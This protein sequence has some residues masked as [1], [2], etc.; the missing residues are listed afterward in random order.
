[1][2]CI[3]KRKNK[4]MK[5]ATI[6]EN[7]EKYIKRMLVATPTTGNIRMEWAMARY[8]QITPVNWSA[9][10]MT[11]WLHPYVP[12]NYGVADA[13]NLITKVAVEENYEWLLL[14]EHDN[15]IPIDAFIKFNQY[16]RENKV[17]VVS[18]L[19]YTRSRP[20]EPLVFRGRGNS[21]YTKWKMGDK[22]WCDAV[23]TGCLLI[24]VSILKAMW[25]ESPEY[26]CG[27]TTTRRVFEVPE[28]MW[29]D[30]EMGQMNIQT[31]TSDLHWCTRIM[32][33]NFFTKAGWKKYAKKE[34]PFLIDSNIFSKHIDPNGQQ[35]P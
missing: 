12:L 21:Y 32:E 10:M 24:S 16:M 27:D 20:S 13:Q 14:I 2:A 28:K 31:G 35:Y 15:I 5:L 22:I 25:N 26:K 6:K 29:Y 23:P 18:G 34:F 30:P 9:V 17:P 33:G 7:S 4:C 3:R 8:G 11:Q 1:M 19:Y